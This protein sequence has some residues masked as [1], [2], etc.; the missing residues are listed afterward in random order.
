MP[1]RWAP[2]RQ[3]RVGVMPREGTAADIRWFDV[4]ACYVF[5]PLN[6]YDE[7]T[8]SCWTSCGTRRCSPQAIPSCP[9]TRRWTDGRST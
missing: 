4:N 7:P 3:A 1:Y 2:E 6:A 5:H 9:A 8:A